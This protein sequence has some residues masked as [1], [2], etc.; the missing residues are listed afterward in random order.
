MAASL[1]SGALLRGLIQAGAAALL[2]L[3]VLLLARWQAIALER[4]T[5][6][7][8]ARGIVQIVAVGSVLGLLLGGPDWTGV[9]LLLAMIVVAARIAARRAK[10]LPGAFRSA[11]VGIFLGAGT[12]IAL[13]VLAGVIDPKVS[14]LVPVGSML[15]SN[16]MNTCAQSLERFRADLEAHVGQIEAAL[17]LG[18]A[19][20]RTVAPY[21]QAAVRA[22]LIPRIDALSSLG[23]V[24]IPGLMAGMVLSGSDPVY[25]ATYQF[26][27]IAMIYAASGLTALA[28]TTIIREHAFTP[29]EQLRRVGEEG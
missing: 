11:L 19:P 3:A 20:E 10:G 23:I 18:A 6:T 1:L 16:T 9:L 24:W 2:A 21:T 26:A 8:L 29:A 25:A 4:E 5:L 28:S 27:V 15:I 22:S 17:A 14:T 13:M 7:A 12:V